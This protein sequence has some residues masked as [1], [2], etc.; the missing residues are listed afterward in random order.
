MKIEEMSFFEK[1]NGLCPICS[2]DIIVA[3]HDYWGCID[4]H[5]FVHLH[6]ESSTYFIDIIEM[7]PIINERGMLGVV[8]LLAK[9]VVSINVP[10]RDK[11]ILQLQ[12]EDFIYSLMHK[13]MNKLET[14]MLLR[15]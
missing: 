1:L 2:K 9:E 6:N 5:F 8:F 12:S 14:V 15:P 7:Y 13:I 10:N 11:I 4:A 3:D